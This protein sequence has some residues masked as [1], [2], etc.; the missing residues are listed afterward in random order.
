MQPFLKWAGNKSEV[1]STIGTHI[2][3]TITTYH[4]IFLGSGAMLLSLLCECRDGKR[5]IHH[6]QAYDANPSLINLW[7]MI[8]ENPRQF[9]LRVQ[10]LHFKES[11]SSNKKYF[12]YC[13][14]YKY[15]SLSNKNSTLACAMYYFLN[16]RCFK[17]I[18]K[19]NQLGELKPGFG[20]ALSPLLT[21]DALLAIHLL[22][23]PVTF[24]CCDYRRALMNVKKAEVVYLD[25]PYVGTFNAYTSSPF[26][27]DMQA[28]LF[29][30]CKT[31]IGP[32]MILSYSDIEM[33]RTVFA[34]EKYHIV[35]V[36][37]FG[38]EEVIIMRK[39]NC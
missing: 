3:S 9:F 25:P 27:I 17:G 2:P 6:F 20:N 32:H 10:Y 34:D 19:M 26:S 39:N 8:K 16:R 22:I 15:N 35:N 29:Q 24:Q 28:Y 36:M 12:F 18:M 7:I 21:L 13:L 31:T 38:R 30:W 5:T 1:A 23:Q 14:R 33:I 11:S 4:E 37:S